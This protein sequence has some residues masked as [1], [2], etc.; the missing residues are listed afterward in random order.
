VH[1]AERLEP[2]QLDEIAANAGRTENKDY[3]SFGQ[4]I[5]TVQTRH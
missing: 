4:S 2:R 3:L 1:V 5:I